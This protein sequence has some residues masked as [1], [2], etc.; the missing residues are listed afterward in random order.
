M[1]ANLLYTWLVILREGLEATLII[2][3]ILSYLGKFKADYA[4]RHVWI[5]VLGA[6]SI[7]LGLGTVMVLLAVSFEGIIGK[8]FEA[9]VSIF[10]VTVLTYMII[11]MSRNAS[12]LKGNLEEKMAL[13]LTN[14][15]LMGIVVLSFVSVFREGLETVLFLTVAFSFDFSSALL[16]LISG[17]MFIGVIGYL[18]IVIG[19]RLPIQS[20]FKYT[21]IILII[22]AAGILGYGIHELV[23]VLEH[24]NI[25]LGI[26]GEPIWDINWL[27]S[28]SSFLGQILKSLVGYDANPELLRVIFYVSYW[29]ILI[30]YLNS[31]FTHRSRVKKGEV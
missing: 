1:F 21:S 5:G 19:Y 29:V 25:N 31:K 22:F 24:Y 6:L 7:S 3:I 13:H 10:A 20:I 23:E 28:E 18:I 15:D 12:K 30:S 2:A 14:R 9:T 17:L 4:K 8:L 11:W 26:L 27:I 16:G